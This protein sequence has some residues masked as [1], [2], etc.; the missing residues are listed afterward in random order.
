MRT[1][2]AGRQL[3]SYS[4]YIAHLTLTTPLG[5]PKSASESV[6]PYPNRTIPTMS[7]SI[8]GS[9]RAA[10]H[11]DPW[12]KSS[13]PSLSTYTE[14]K[15]TRSA[16]WHPRT[17][18][19]SP[20]S[21]PPPL[22]SP[23]SALLQVPLG[24][25]QATLTPPLFSPWDDLPSKLQAALSQQSLTLLQPLSLSKSGAIHARHLQYHSMNS[26]NLCL[27]ISSLHH[28]SLSFT[29]PKLSPSPL[30]EACWKYSPRNNTLTLTV[31]TLS[32]QLLLASL[33]FLI[34]PPSCYYSLPRLFLPQTAPIFLSHLI[35]CPLLAIC[36]PLLQKLFK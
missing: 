24:R 22:Q 23:L 16:G 32:A 11:T 2:A 26:R 14:P 33:C 9:T 31:L 8:S 36:L 4:G 15:D 21:L 34:S 3:A 28:P 13:P 35:T 27:P 7:W 12:Y 5:S 29:L 30:K 20:P 18:P 19:L 1:S 25:S 17:P 10:P 6:A